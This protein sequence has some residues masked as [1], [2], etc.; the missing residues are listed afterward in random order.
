M[1]FWW[2]LVCV[3]ALLSAPTLFIHPNSHSGLAVGQQST[4]AVESPFPLTE[5][6]KQFVELYDMLGQDWADCLCEKTT[7]VSTTNNSLAN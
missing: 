6:Q 7:K 3:V 4:T 5:R 2:S 1:F